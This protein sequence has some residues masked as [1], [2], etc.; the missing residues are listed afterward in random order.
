MK[1]LTNIEIQNS[2]DMAF[3]IDKGVD[4]QEIIN[5]KLNY[6]SAVAHTILSLTFRNDEDDQVGKICFIRSAGS[7]WNSKHPPNDQRGEESI[8]LSNSFNSL[9]KIVNLIKARKY[10]EEN[11]E[12]LLDVQLSYQDSKFTKIL[13]NV[14]TPD[15]KLTVFATLHSGDSFFN[16]S[17]QTLRYCNKIRGISLATSNK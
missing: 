11:K 6:N 5:R 9:S 2:K 8:I 14:L 12:K 7:E 17:L 15:F 10:A 1:N 3:I 13:Q 4:I 16:D